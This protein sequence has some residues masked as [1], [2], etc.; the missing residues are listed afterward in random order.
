M[1]DFS[2]YLT[3]RAGRNDYVGFLGPRSLTK[4]NMWDDADSSQC[5]QFTKETEGYTT[6]TATT[7]SVNQYDHLTGTVAVAYIDQANVSSISDAQIIETAD[8][9]KFS[10]T[11][12]SDM[13]ITEPCSE[14]ESLQTFVTYPEEQTDSDIEEE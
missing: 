9:A 2:K 14:Y 4:Y 3:I 12:T 11:I 8:K 5:M 13:F 10:A 7:V 6:L 1:H